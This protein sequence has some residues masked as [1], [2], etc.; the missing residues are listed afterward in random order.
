M[1]YSSSYTAHDFESGDILTA[2]DLNAMDDQ[3]EGITNAIES[4]AAGG[5][6]TIS[7]D[8]TGVVIVDNSQNSGS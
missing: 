1:A 2:V 3:I 6:Y 5:A 8:T 7:E 4:G